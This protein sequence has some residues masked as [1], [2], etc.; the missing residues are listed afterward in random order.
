MNGEAGKGD[1]YRPV[2]Q[3]VY[4]DNYDFIFRKGKYAP[5]QTPVSEQASE[6]RCLLCG[7]VAFPRPHGGGYI[8]PTLGCPNR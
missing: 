7:N 2:N 6:V 1:S 8:C 5:E 4:D 3:R